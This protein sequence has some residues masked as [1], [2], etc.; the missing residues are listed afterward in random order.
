MRSSGRR[1]GLGKNI[2][3]MW[4]WL[5][6]ASNSRSLLATYRGWSSVRGNSGLWTGGGV[7]PVVALEE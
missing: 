7:A 2:G 3:I 5:G 1:W 6:F 4:A